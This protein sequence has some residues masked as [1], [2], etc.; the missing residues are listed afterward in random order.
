MLFLWVVLLVVEQASVR[1]GYALAL[2]SLLCLIF[3]GA[4][5]YESEALHY[6]AENLKVSTTTAVDLKEPSSS[7]TPLAPPGIITQFLE[8]LR[9]RLGIGGGGEMNLRQLRI[10]LLTGFE[11][12]LLVLVAVIALR[13]P[14]RGHHGGSALLEGMRRYGLSLASVLFLLYALSLLAAARTERLA[15]EVLYRTAHGE[16]HYDARLLGTKLPD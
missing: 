4:W 16:A 12:L 3:L 15:S 2:V 10:A 9:Q 13:Q 5:G 1:S 6:A 11:M 7:A 14:A 8:W